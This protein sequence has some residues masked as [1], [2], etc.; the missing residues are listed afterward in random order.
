[1]KPASVARGQAVQG[2][3]GERLVGAGKEQQDGAEC[4]RHP[5][6]LM[7]LDRLWLLPP[8]ACA[9]GNPPH[10]RPGWKGEGRVG[11][12]QPQCVCGW[13]QEGFPGVAVGTKPPVVDPDVFLEVVCLVGMLLCLTQMRNYCLFRAVPCTCSFHGE[14]KMLFPSC[15]FVPQLLAGAACVYQ[16]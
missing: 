2:E 12:E 5:L 15:L 7:L 6:S 3:S 14:G 9:P 1:M 13:S 11:M 4:R 16:H 8:S 10:L